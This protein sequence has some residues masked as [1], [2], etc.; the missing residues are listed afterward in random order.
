MLWSLE[1]SWLCPKES[2]LRTLQNTL[3]HFSW[4]SAILLLLTPMTDNSRKLQVLRSASSVSTV[5]QQG[6]KGSSSHKWIFYATSNSICVGFFAS[7]S[8]LIWKTKENMQHLSLKR[9]A[10]IHLDFKVC[11]PLFFF[12]F[13]FYLFFP[14]AL[15]PS[16]EQWGEKRTCMH[17]HRYTNKGEKKK[18]K[19]R[20]RSDISWSQ[21]A[22][23]PGLH[24]RCHEMKN[25]I[26]CSGSPWLWKTYV[27]V[28]HTLRNT[29]A[30]QSMI[31]ACRV[32]I[33]ENLRKAF[34]AQV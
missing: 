25:D 29:A 34:E 13:N 17:T 16:R 2:I 26:I 31:A 30:R 6:Q 33:C 18:G 27:Q 10:F 12:F 28:A 11:P 1:S 7:F 20:K 19:K 5:Q 3:A 9:E 8:Q 21:P 23:C 4:W 32:S 22:S 24:Q 15:I 14:N